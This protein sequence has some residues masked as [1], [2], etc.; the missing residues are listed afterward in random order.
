LATEPVG[1]VDGSL[2]QGQLGRNGPEFELVPVTATAMAIVATGGQ[3]YR[4]TA[5]ALGPGLVQW[6]DAIALP[7]ASSRSLE[8]KERQDLLHRDFG[9]QRV[10]V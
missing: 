2:V 1:E 7:T 9:A 5:A 4:E 10:E 8:P 3:V 6:A